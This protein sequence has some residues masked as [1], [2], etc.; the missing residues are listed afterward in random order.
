MSQALVI[1]LTGAV[2]TEPDG[3]QDCRDILECGAEEKPDDRRTL[4]FA[5][6]DPPFL[7][8]QREKRSADV[9]ICYSNSAAPSAFLS[10]KLFT[11]GFL[12]IPDLPLNLP[13]DFLG[14]S[15]ISHAGITH[16]FPNLFLQLAGR[17]LDS[18]LNLVLCAG[19]H[20]C[21]PPYSNGSQ[22]ISSAHLE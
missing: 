17:L 18:T 13:A 8:R 19:F 5:L 21:S 4:L 14:G 9:V 3:S 2:G 10:R 20:L 11:E 16:G 1:F 15:P 7:A 22:F 12:D 6:G